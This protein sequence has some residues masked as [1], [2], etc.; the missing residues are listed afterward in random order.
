MNTP[1]IAGAT[2]TNYGNTAELN[3]MNY[4]QAMATI[5]HEEWEK[6]VKVEHKKMVG[7]VQR[8]LSSQTRRC[9]RECQTDGLRMGDEEESHRQSS[10][11]ISSTRLQANRGT[12]L[13][14]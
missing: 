10:S 13:F 1:S 5:H 6:A 11:P 7:Q 14:N 9:S 3:V 8:L 2:R 4:K 12:T